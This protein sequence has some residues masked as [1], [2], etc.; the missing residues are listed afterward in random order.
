[1]IK[2]NERSLFSIHY[3]QGVKL[4]SRLRLNLSHLK[5]HKFRYNFKECVT[6]MCGFGLE[7]EST[8]HF[9]L[10]CQL[11]H[12]ERSEPLKSLYDIDLATNELN[13]DF[14]INLV[15][16]DSDKYN[17]ELNRKI[18]LNC[19]IYLKATKR[20]DEPLLLPLTTGFFV[21]VFIFVYICLYI[22]IYIYIYIVIFYMFYLFLFFSS[23]LT[24]LNVY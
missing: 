1:M 9:F 7:I 2:S 18:L 16:F 19:I 6:L 4:L 17:K 15:L 10:W 8:Q 13:R 14:I 5:E 24:M 11:S 21:F 23:F 22:Y 3:P 20:F 12:L